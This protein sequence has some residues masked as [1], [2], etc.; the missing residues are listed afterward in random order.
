MSNFDKDVDIM[1]D[2]GTNAESTIMA[3]IDF[4][5]QQIVTKNNASFQELKVS[6]STDFCC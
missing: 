6:S 1:M 4:V 2:N 3:H 5:G